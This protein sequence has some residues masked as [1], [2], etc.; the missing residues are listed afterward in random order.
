MN[1]FKIL[2]NILCRIGRRIKITWVFHRLTPERIRRLQI[3]V[4]ETIDRYRS[5]NRVF[6]Y[7]GRALGDVT[8]MMAFVEEYKRQN[9][10]KSI[11][12]LAGSQLMEKIAGTFTGYDRII[13]LT[14]RQNNK[15]INALYFID[16]EITYSLAEK[17]FFR[18]PALY[19]YYTIREFFEDTNHLKI[20][21]FLKETTSADA[22]G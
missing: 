18:L 16:S 15:L 3:S 5:E 2:K 14:R 1:V 17:Q 11:V 4:N 8:Y 7:T 10:E 19:E 20:S 13:L 22:V 21:E 12:V 9:P 6:V